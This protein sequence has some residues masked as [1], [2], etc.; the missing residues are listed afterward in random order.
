LGH[1]GVCALAFAAVIVIPETVRHPDRVI[2]VRL[3]LGVPP[4]MRT[5]MVGA[6]LGVFAAFSILGFFSSLVPTFLHGVLGVENLAYVGAASFLIFITA[7]ITQAVSARTP[8]RRSVSVGLPLLLVALG[9]LESALFAQ[10]LWLFLAGTIVGGIAVGLVFRSGLSE[11][12]RLA[13][14]RR[15]AA[16]MSTFFA[17]AYL[18]L[19]LPV[20]LTGLIS[21]VTGTLDASAYTSVFVAAIVLAALAVALRT[22]DTTTAS[23]PSP[24]PMSRPMSRRMPRA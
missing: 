12:N 3:R 11:L 9:M 21:Q 24:R 18:G 14:P 19:G 23:A 15:R 13:E 5:V 8:A 17:A 20:V 7:A 4:S 1:L 6:C 16:V 10:A 2:K 22:Y